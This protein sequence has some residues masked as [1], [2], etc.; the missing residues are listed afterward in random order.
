VAASDQ[1]EER[2]QVLCAKIIALSAL[3]DR[4]NDRLVEHRAVDAIKQLDLDEVTV[5]VAVLCVSRVRKLCSLCLCDT[6]DLVPASYRLRAEFPQ[7]TIFNV[8]VERA[9]TGTPV[10]PW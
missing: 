3:G 5:K 2:L 9:V 7:S 6:F 8:E 10:F 4:A 1:L